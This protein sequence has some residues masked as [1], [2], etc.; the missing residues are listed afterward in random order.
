MYII[1][2]V[3]DDVAAWGW[4][5]HRKR[6]VLIMLLRAWIFPVL[7]GR[8]DFRFELSQ[9]GV[10]QYFRFGAALRLLFHRQT[11]YDWTAY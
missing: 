10:E 7:R 5:V 1:I 6:Q 2:R 9:H 11:R 3:V 8:S 4:R